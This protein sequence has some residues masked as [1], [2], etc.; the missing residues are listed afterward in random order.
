MLRPITYKFEDIIPLDVLT[1]YI[2][3][4]H[5]GLLKFYIKSNFKYSAEFMTQK[6]VNLTFNGIIP[7]M[8]ILDE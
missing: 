2:I 4:A 1:N 6:M 3:G 5:Y 7:M 8:G